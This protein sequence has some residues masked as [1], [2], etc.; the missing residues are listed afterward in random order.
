M[1][2]W[3]VAGIGTAA[4]I[5]FCSL[6]SPASPGSADAT[7]ITEIVVANANFPVALAVAPAGRLFYTEHCT[8]DV[9]VVDA[10]GVLQPDPFAHLDIAEPCGDWGLIGIE[11][12]PDY[13]ANGYVYVYYIEEVTASP[14]VARA[15][16]VRFTDVSNIGTDPL[17]LLD[18]PESLPDQGIREHVAGNIHFGPDG[19]LYVTIG[20]FRAPDE[21]MVSQ[22]L[23]SLK[24]KI[25]RLEKADGSAPLD[26]PFVGTPGADPR[27]YAYGFRNSYDFAFS[28]DGEMY[29]ADNGP[30]FCDELNHVVPG[31]NYG[32]NHP[33]VSG[34]CDVAVGI[35]PIHWLARDGF[36]PWA[37]GS[38]VAP[39]GME[40][41]DG[42]TY[43]A[44]GDSLLLCEWNMDRMKRFQL[45]GP[46]EVEDMGPIVGACRT[47]VEVS[48]L[49]PIYFSTHDGIRRMLV[50]SDSDGDID[51]QD[52]CPAIANAGQEDSDGDGVG[53]AC[54]NCPNAPNAAQADWNGDGTGDACQDSDGDSLGRA[55][56]QPAGACASSVAI[57]VFRD[58]VERFMGTDPALACPATS[59]ANDEAVDAWG[60]DFNDDRTVNVIDLV[61][62]YPR[63]N[64]AP[65]DPD[66]RRR[67]DLNGDAVIG[68]GD[69]LILLLFARRTC[70]SAVTLAV[71]DNWFCD[72]S[73]EFG[74]CETTIRVGDTVTWRYDAGSS[75]HTAT[76]CG[77]SCDSPTPSPVWD[78]GLMF[79]GD[80]FSQNFD[81]AGNYLY[82]CSLHPF[83]M[84]G[85]IIVE[86]R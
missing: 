62:L 25:L 23:G 51:G 61:M 7:I 41:I 12:D 65:G 3:T 28:E 63:L 1:K 11:L 20:D 79:V 84:R 49:G 42:D 45:I 13:Q 74:N 60:P 21:D 58:C 69:L 57:P 4:L 76:E 35:Q 73:Y 66:Y 18:D 40:Y 15:V 52:N 85:T 75:V 47:D 55:L 67:F 77:I 30:E 54:D 9:R 8:G 16:V 32:W 26:N 78:S 34:T 39:T 56:P 19:K 80:S 27:I 22:D 37:P 50:D 43:P 53:D 70:S 71:G 46:D 14:Q 6:G 44:F 29:A 86:D 82:Y 10:A 5:V 24:G 2:R 72:S 64:S 33:Y 38:P 81:T 48:P 17:V 31:G 59:A 36:D 83:D 68:G